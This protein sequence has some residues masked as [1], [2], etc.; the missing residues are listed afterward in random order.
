MLLTTSEMQ[1][2]KNVFKMIGAWLRANASLKACNGGI[3]FD[4]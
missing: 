2:I 1:E 3:K 4:A